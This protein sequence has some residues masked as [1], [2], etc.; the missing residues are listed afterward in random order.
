MI[1]FR[2]VSSWARKHA[3]VLL[4]Q[5]YNKC[6]LIIWI[7]LSKFIRFLSFWTSCYSWRLEALGRICWRYHRELESLGDRMGWLEHGFGWCGRAKLGWLFLRLTYYSQH[8]IG[9]VLQ[10]AGINYLQYKKFTPVTWQLEKH[11]VL[12]MYYAIGHFSKYIPE[13]SIRIDLKF[14][15]VD[16]DIVGT[17]FLRPDG[18]RAIVILNKYLRT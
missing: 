6:S 17:A 4:F 2:I 10:T 8:Y 5:L 11:F 12:Q 9:R 7:W 18:K 3:L 13:D 15:K 14:A 16:P 1:S